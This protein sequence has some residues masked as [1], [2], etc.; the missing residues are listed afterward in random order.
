MEDKN[1]TGIIQHEFMK[2]KS[3]LA[4]MTAF[5]Y[6]TW[7]LVDE[8]KAVDAVYLDISEAFDAL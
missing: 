3:C 4:N 2:V 1:V 6:E 7:G 5:Y 8:Q